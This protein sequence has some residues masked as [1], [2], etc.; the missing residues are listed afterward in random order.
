MKRLRRNPRTAIL[1]EAAQAKLCP[2][3]ARECSPPNLSRRE[4]VCRNLTDGA[5]K[6]ELFSWSD[7][8]K[9]I[10]DQWIGAVPGNPPERPLV[11]IVEG[12]DDTRAMYALALSAM[13]FDVV[14]TQDG[15]EAY[16]RAWEI[17]P[18]DRGGPA[19]AQIRRVAVPREFEA[20]PAYTVHSGCRDERLRS[21]V[22]VRTSE[23][24]RLR[25]VLSKALSA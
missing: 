3:R 5:K 11:L 2:I 14:A 6:G 19:D 25:G 18:D 12:H 10:R 13:G 16:R 21:T 23:S 4:S 20:E 15:T 7:D 1:Q 9:R 8:F 24:R 22:T 17:H